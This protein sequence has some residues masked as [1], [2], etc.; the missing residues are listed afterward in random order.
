MESF[1]LNEQH[2]GTSVLRSLRREGRVEFPTLKVADGAND[3]WTYLEDTLP[4]G[5]RVLAFYH[6]LE[7]LFAVMEAI[8]GKSDTRAYTQHAKYRD[9]YAINC[10]KPQTKKP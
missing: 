2:G 7:H 5:D 3:N 1:L 9:I 8:Y 4:Q 6:A 10:A